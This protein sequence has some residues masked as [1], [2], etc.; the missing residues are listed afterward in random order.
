MK[1]KMLK[2]EDPTTFYFVSLHEIRWVRKRRVF[3]RKFEG[4]VR[5]PEYCWYCGCLLHKASS[6]HPQFRTLDHVIPRSKGGHSNHQNLR[7]ACMWCNS[8]KSSMTSD[9]F[10][11]RY[12]FS[13]FHGEIEAYGAYKMLLTKFPGFASIGL[14]GNHESTSQQPLPIRARG[15]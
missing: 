8:H 9:E 10:R 1:L 2:A 12:G 4:K 7:L 15:L 11:A 3:R 5:E 13:M 14:G 6:W